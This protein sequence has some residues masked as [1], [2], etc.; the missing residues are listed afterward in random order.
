[1]GESSDPRQIYFRSALFELRPAPGQEDRPLGRRE[2]L[3]RDVATGKEC[4]CPIGLVVPTRPVTL[5]VELRSLDAV[6]FAY[7]V[8]PL[9]QVLEASVLTGNPVCWC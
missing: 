6:Y 2:I 1:M 8:E 9:E 5:R 4:I 3:Y 7:I